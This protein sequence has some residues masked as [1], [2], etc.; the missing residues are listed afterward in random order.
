[1]MLPSS[2][3]RLITIL[4]HVLLCGV[5]GIAIFFYHPLFSGIDIPVTAWVS[6][7][8]TLALLIIAFYIN[9]SIL[10]PRFL[11]RNQLPYYFIMVLAL[12]AAVVLI[13]VWVD[14]AL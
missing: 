11:L 5:F 7:S 1:M 12:V 9:I 13:N 4:A 2:K 8:I 3:S 6:Q 10:V 14:I